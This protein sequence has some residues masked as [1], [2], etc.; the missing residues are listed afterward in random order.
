MPSP[1]ESFPPDGGKDGEEHADDWNIWSQPDSGFAAG[2]NW[3]EASPLAGQVDRNN[4][5]DPLRLISICSRR[6]RERALILDLTQL[7]QATLQRVA[8]HCQDYDP[9]QAF[10]PWLLERVDA[11]I[12][13]LRIRDIELVRAGTQDVTQ[14]RFFDLGVLLGINHKHT[15]L[16]CITINSLDDET[17]RVFYEVCIQN[18]TERDMQRDGFP[19]ERTQELIE[20]AIAAVR[21]ALTSAGVSSFPDFDTLEDLPP[22]WEEPEVEPDE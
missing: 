4:P 20:Q 16:A 3:L 12:E 19:L 1:R 6:L 9:K 14:G 13:A 18:R 21:N 22:T 5:L 15:P 11:A 8:L 17:R 7:I 10:E 2:K